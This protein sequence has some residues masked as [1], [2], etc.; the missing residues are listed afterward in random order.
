MCV[1]DLES[2]CEEIDDLGLVAADQNINTSQFGPQQ[3][4]VSNSFPMESICEDTV[5]SEEKYN[6]FIPT[7]RSGEWSDIGHRSYMEDTHI[8]IPDLA[9]TFNNKY[10]GEETV[11]FYG[12]FDGHGGKGASKFVR[13][14]L[15][16][17]I[18][19]DANFP[20]ELEKVV[21]RSF[22][23]TD[24]A[25]ARS[26]A[27]ESTLS[28]GTTAL[29]AMIFG[30]SLLVANAGDC[31]AVLSRNGLAFEMSKDHRPCCDKERLRIESLGGFVEDGYLNG[32][33]GVTRAIGNWHIQGL[34][35]T[36]N[37][38]GP[39]SAEPELKLVTLTKED[40]FLI[41]GSDGI[42]DVFMNQNAVDFVRRRLQD[43]NDVKRC[44]KEMVEEAMKRH[45]LDNLTVVI[46]CFQAEPP[47][48]VVVQRGR[49]RR[50]ISAE[51]LL[52][53]KFHLEG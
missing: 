25:F 18:V 50:S 38:V 9:R 13:D 5:V 49:V 3:I 31:R 6:N 19:D 42:W 33:L 1:Q 29:T 27:L 51:G 43:H 53:L 44:C 37:Q 21:T 39:L 16:R 36:D 2:G 45:A 10:I 26:C 28:S 52:N 22:V 11:S 20:M 4:T 12:V 41:I 7:L 48:P 32:Q 24:A 8:C 14:N 23:E 30:R 17:I 40:E 15:P 34:K 46:V 35:E 47:P